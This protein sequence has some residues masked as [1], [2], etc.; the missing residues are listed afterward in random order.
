MK[1]CRRGARSIPCAKTPA[2]R[3]EFA[4]HS[5]FD[6]KGSVDVLRVEEAARVNPQQLLGW[7]SFRANSPLR[8]SLR[9]V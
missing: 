7:F 3:Q 2:T 5:F 8:P 4:Q 6:G 1:K 9:E